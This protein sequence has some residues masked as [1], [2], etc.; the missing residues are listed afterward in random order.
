MFM[1]ML[2]VMWFEVRVCG[3]VLGDE[4]V[5]RLMR[6]LLRASINCRKMLFAS[7]W[8]TMG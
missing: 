2:F 1:M 3:A 4:H 8:L 7:F 5:G 6:E